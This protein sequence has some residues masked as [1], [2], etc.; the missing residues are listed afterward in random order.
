V[1]PGSITPH[2]DF[3]ATST[4]SARTRA[5]VTRRSTTTT[6]RSSTSAPRT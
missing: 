3:D 2:T 1:K 4:S 6:V 5:A